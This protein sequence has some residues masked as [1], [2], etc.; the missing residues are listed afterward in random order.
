[1]GTVF[2]SVASSYFTAAFAWI[3]YIA[4]S[5][6]S[7]PIF[8]GYSLIMIIGGL[9]K[10]YKDHGDSFDRIIGAENCD[11][12]YLKTLLLILTLCEYTYSGTTDILTQER[13]HQTLRFLETV[14]AGSPQ[15]NRVIA[16]YITNRWIFHLNG[17]ELLDH[18]ATQVPATPPAPPPGITVGEMFRAN[19]GIQIEPDGTFVQALVFFT[20]GEAAI[21]VMRRTRESQEIPSTMIDWNEPA[22]TGTGTGT[23]A[24]LTS[25]DADMNDAW[26]GDQGYSP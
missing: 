18:M 25:D 14:M 10:L 3:Y 6:W 4:M 8:T 26:M 2:E 12:W 15:Q 21:D 23:L 17:G 19:T 5:I 16:L 13:S 22:G 7:F 24:R 9:F 20:A 11:K 1:M